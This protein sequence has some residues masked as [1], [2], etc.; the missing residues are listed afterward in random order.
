MLGK[1]ASHLAHPENASYFRERPSWLY[2]LSEVTSS[3]ILGTAN[4]PGICNDE[5]KLLTLR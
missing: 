1:I 5:L 2:L 4:R 3:A